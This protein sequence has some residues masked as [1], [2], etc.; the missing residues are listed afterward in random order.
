MKTSDIIRIRKTVEK[1]MDE[2]RYEHTLGVEYT[3]CAL[4]MKYH[5]DVRKA[6]LAG[7]L[8]DSAKCM[9]DK[10]KIELCNKNKV[11]ISKIE[12]EHPFLL[13]GKAGALLAEHK[14]GID[15]ED[16]LNS[17][18]YHTTGRPGMSD[19]EKIIYI[20][21]FIEPNRK[22]LSCMEQ[23]RT[24]AFTDLDKC[25]VYILKACLEHLEENRDTI[26]PM[27]KET[28]DYYVKKQKE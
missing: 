7:L 17:I 4:A 5:V 16:I 24:L 2:K 26:D 23:A 9:E 8:H 18:I 21:D 27:T 13:H 1:F 15:D 10:K 19:L 22:N 3:A 28:Y 20:A 11:P 12:K 6:Q 25:L 14:F